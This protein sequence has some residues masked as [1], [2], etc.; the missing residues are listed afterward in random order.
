[1]NISVVLQSSLDGPTYDT[2][3]FFLL[4]VSVEFTNISRS[5]L[6]PSRT[7]RTPATPNVPSKAPSWTSQGLPRTF[8]RHPKLLNLSHSMLILLIVIRSYQTYFLF[9]V[10]CWGHISSIC[11]YIYIHIPKTSFSSIGF[12]SIIGWWRHGRK[13]GTWFGGKFSCSPS[14]QSNIADIDEMW[15]QNV[16]PPKCKC[17]YG[18]LHVHAFYSLTKLCL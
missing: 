1:M 5:P 14:S 13:W 15:L 12:L 9:R 10:S 11:T 17:W 7:P 18:W 3:N 6:R 4:N 2:C 8:Q 16:G